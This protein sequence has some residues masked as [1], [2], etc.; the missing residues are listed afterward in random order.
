MSRT[1]TA[2]LI[3]IA[4]VL[5]ALAGPRAETHLAWEEVAVPDDVT[6]WL[7][8]SEAALGDVAS[9]KEKGVIWADSAGRR[10]SVSVVYLHGFSASRVEAFP[11]PDS[12]AAALGAN[13]FYSRLAGHGRDN[14]DFGRSTA[15]EWYQSAVE[16]IRIGEA[17][18]DSLI[19]IGLSTGATLAAAASLEPELSRR[20]KAQIWISPNLTV[21]DPRSEV[22]LW[23]WGS[24][25]LRLMAGE[26]YSWEPQ[27]ELHAQIGN[28]SYD[29]RVLLEVVSLTDAVRSLPFEEIRTPTLVFYSGSDTVVNPEATERLFADITAPKDSVVVRRALD[30]NMHVLVGDALGPENTVPFARR[31]VAFVKALGS[32]TD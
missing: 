25:L 2:L 26:T 20:W 15:D 21:H 7:A 19:V 9:G 14:E 8:D 6:T 5:L 11:Y 27:N 13:L 16:A 4:L 23:P 31:T 30:R 3:L 17:I 10:T 32:G 28:T 1:W 18:G 22:I 12:V 29:S 24:V